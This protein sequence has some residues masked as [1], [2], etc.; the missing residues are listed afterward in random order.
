MIPTET[1]MDSHCRTDNSGWICVRIA[2]H[3]YEGGWQHGS[4]LATEIAR[5]LD[6]GKY[7]CTWDTGE[8]FDVFIDAAVRQFCPTVDQEFLDEIRGIADGAKA[9]GI[10]TSFNEILAWNGYLDLMSWWPTHKAQLNPQMGIKLW[11]GRGGHHC[12]AF[13]ATGSYTASG[14]IIMAH[15]T[16]DRY[17]LGDSYNILFDIQPVAGHRILMQGIPGCISSLTDF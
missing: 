9:S 14:N 5:A 8:R 3:P 4:L 1:K 7:L 15:N 13:I 2:G 11:K 10:D 16:W 6:T 17:A 12:S